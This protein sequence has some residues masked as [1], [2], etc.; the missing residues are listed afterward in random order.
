MFGLSAIGGGWRQELILP[1]YAS[2]SLGR[3][4]ARKRCHRKADR[5]IWHGKNSSSLAR[6]LLARL[7]AELPLSFSRCQLASCNQMHPVARVLIGLGVL[8]VVAGSLWHLGGRW[9]PIGRLPGDVV[10]ERG[11]ARFYFPIVTCLI[12]SVLMSVAAWLWRAWQR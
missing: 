8:L 10:L 1:E 7:P 11:N 3:I 5:A 9:L 6:R 12:I 4:P 2:Y